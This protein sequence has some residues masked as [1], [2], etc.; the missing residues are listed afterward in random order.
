MGDRARDEIGRRTGLI[1][2]QALHQ[3]VRGVF[4]QAAGSRLHQGKPTRALVDTRQVHLDIESGGH[5]F[6]TQ[7]KPAVIVPDFP[8]Q[9]KDTAT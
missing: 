3:R 6:C 1:T 5:D 4:A 9:A 2:S 8:V 7:R